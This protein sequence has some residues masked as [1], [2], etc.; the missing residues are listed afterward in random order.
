MGSERGRWEDLTCP[1][2]NGALA[3]FSSGT[4]SEMR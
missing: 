2:Y 3:N 1:V 4:Y